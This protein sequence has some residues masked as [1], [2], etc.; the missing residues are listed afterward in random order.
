MRH[1]H[2]AFLRTG[3]GARAPRDLPSP[4]GSG[5]QR[6]LAT[7]TREGYLVDDEVTIEAVTIGRYRGD[8]RLSRIVSRCAVSGVLSAFPHRHRGSKGCFASR[9]DAEQIVDS[10]NHKRHFV[11]PDEV[12]KL[13]DESIRVCNQWGKRNI[14][15]FLKRTRELGYEVQS[16]REASDV[17]SN[18]HRFTCVI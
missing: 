17:D 7:Q 6:F 10:T 14:E 1:A 8:A 12:P 9:N 18:P 3:P 4:V 5:I 16:V 11:A 2:R 15:K 13:T